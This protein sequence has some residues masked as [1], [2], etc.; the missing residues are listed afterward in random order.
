MES[1]KNF[2]KLNSPQSARTT[3]RSTRRGRS[4]RLAVAPVVSLVL[5][6]VSFGP[7]CWA[8]SRTYVHPMTVVRLY[9]PLLRLSNHQA[10]PG[11][12]LRQWGETCGGEKV[13]YVMRVVAGMPRSEWPS[14]LSI[15]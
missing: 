10:P 4:L 13:V 3:E 15:D 9:F 2:A 5:Y 11:S 1:S 12:V 6:A 8:V 7:A 14:H